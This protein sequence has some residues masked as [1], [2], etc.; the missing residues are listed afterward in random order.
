MKNMISGSRIAAH[1]AGKDPLKPFVTDEFRTITRGEFEMSSNRLARAYAGLGVKEGDMVTIALPNGI[2][3]FEATF[4]AFKLGATPQPISARLPKF[5]RDAIIEIANPS[6][7]VGVEEGDIV[8]RAWLA[9]GFVP[10]ASLSDKE[11]PEITTKY[12]KA[13]TSGGSTGRPKL[14]VAEQPA[15]FDP[16]TP[17]LQMEVDR[18][19]LMPGPLYHNAPF[20]FSMSALFRGNHVV[21]TTRF[22]AMETLRLVETHKVDWL[23]L[24]PTMMQRIWR[25]PQEQRLAHDMSSLRVMLHLAAPCPAWLK[26]EWINWLGPEI[27]HELYAGTEAQ[28]STWITGTEWL[29]H[30]GSV[31]KPS[32][33]CA[34]KIVGENGETLPPGEIG[35]VYMIPLAGQGVTYHYVGATPKADD[36]GWESIGDMGHMDEDGYLYLA[37]RQTDMILCGG[38][39][40]YPAEVEGAIE[41]FEGIR[42]CAVIGLP[43]EDLGNRVHAIIDTAGGKLDETAL[44]AHLS[45]RLGRYKIPRSFEYVDEP[46][47][48][49]AGK[50]RRKALREDRLGEKSQ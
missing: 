32:P 12:W 14:I 28:G 34:M 10:D 19:I 38:A 48:S 17:A 21:I 36:E 16:D 18:A 42:S 40:V 7:V 11:L 4:A 35:E 25:L 29:E 6:L 33:N 30:R 47:R 50:V 45:E 23:Y 41:A 37:D 44:L 22:D 24:V 5:E 49:D 26:E 15:Q 9:A 1:W 39:N 31:G 3:F 20:A 13:P 8:G 27:I 43:D 46:L 2:E